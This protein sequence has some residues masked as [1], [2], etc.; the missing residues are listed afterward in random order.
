MDT[1]SEKK[2]YADAILVN[3][4]SIQKKCEFLSIP[5]VV[6]PFI[7]FLINESYIEAIDVAYFSIK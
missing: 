2:S 6:L 5:I 1:H 3:L 7:Y 4:F